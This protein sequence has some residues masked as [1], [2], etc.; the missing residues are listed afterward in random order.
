MFA[1]KLWKVDIFS[2]GKECMNQL[3]FLHNYEK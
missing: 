2:D 3:Q 1:I